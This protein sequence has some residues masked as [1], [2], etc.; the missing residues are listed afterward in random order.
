MLSLAVVLVCQSADGAVPRKESGSS[1][2]QLIADAAQGEA[3]AQYL[4]AKRH[5]TG[6]HVQRSNIRAMEYYKK[7]AEQGH[8]KAM[9][10]LAVA[11]QGGFVVKRSTH[12]AGLW[13]ERLIDQSGRVMDRY[14]SVVEDSRKDS[15]E[16][17]RSTR[18][19]GSLSE[20]NEKLEKEELEFLNYVMDDVRYVFKTYASL[21]AIYANDAKG[22]GPADER[23]LA[24]KRKL[25][26][27]PLLRLKHP[28]NE[29]LLDEYR[30]IICAAQHYLVR[31]S[32]S[33]EEALKYAQHLVS[34]PYEYKDKADAALR[35]GMRYMAGKGVK[36]SREDARE[37]LLIS[38]KLGNERAKKALKSI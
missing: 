6:D 38:A 22:D 20:R 19:A 36:V 13:F 11:Y 12:M 26:D 34:D 25:A 33:G 1:T 24:L 7:A 5:L 2:R 15:E 10:E 9:Y 30:E 29:K 35:M 27:F 14:S 32:P 18:K 8:I 21:S 4:M 37:W 16:G 28:E 31:H 23:V 3:E 17:D